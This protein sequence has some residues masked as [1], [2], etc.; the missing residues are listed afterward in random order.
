[1]TMS[2]A[3]LLLASALL[4]GTAVNALALDRNAMTGAWT[5]RGG[6]NATVYVPSQDPPNFEQA[7]GN[8]Y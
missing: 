4:V 6:S 5:D 3:T 2:K 8:I 7:K 1:M